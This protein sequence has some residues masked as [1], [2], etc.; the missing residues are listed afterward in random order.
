MSAGERPRAAAASRILPGAAPF[1]H[2]AGP[3]GALL[4]HGFTGC[5]ASMRPL[6]AW[7]AEHGISTIGP[8]MPGHGTSW[9]DLERTSWRDWEGEAERALDD[10]TSRCG[11]V[12]AVGLSGGGAMALHLAAEHPDR[13]R[14]VV[15]INPQIHRPELALVPIVR[16]FRRTVKGV[17][18]DINKAGQDELVYDRVPLRAARELR[19][20]IRTAERELPSMRLPLLIFSS[21]VDHVVK[22]ANSRMVIQKAG[23]GQKELVRLPNSYHVATLDHDAELIFRRVAEFARSTASGNH[24]VPR[25]SG[26]YRGSR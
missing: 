18:N 13:L 10:I 16:L 26:T 19:K 9:E 2:E 14:G 3:I 15:A 24:A 20:L 8:R 21:S 23:S 22:P 17:G 12:I 5:P 11:D 7:L 4:L 6:G 1:R 25:S